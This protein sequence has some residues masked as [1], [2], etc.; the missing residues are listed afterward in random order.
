MSIRK[1]LSLA[2]VALS[3]SLLLAAPASAQEEGSFTVKSLTPETALAAARATMAHCRAQGFQVAVA[4]VDRSGVLQAL[5]RDRYAG[6]HTIQVATD[7]A[8][9]AA[10]FKIPTSS[11]AAETQAGKPMSGLRAV[12]RVMAAGG[13]Q[14]IEAAGSLLGAIGVSG[15]PG[16][17]ADEACADAGIKAIADAIEF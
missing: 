17:E 15:A 1:L 14:V 5:L 4:V 6:A 11:L 2:T 16:G 7:K 13:G 3:A 8:W 12:P 9:T 10:S